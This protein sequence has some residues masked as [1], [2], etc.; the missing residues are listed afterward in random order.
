MDKKRIESL[1]ALRGLAALVV[2][3]RHYTTIFSIDYGVP[4]NFNFEFKYGYLGVE[5]FFLISG[6]VI[7][8]TIEQVNTSKEFIVKRFVRLY[9]TYWLSILITTIVILLFGLPKMQFSIKDF[10]LNLTMIQDVVNPILH[11]KHIDGVYWSLAAELLFYGFILLL[12]Q[13]KWLKYI[14]VIGFFWVLISIICIPN[15]ISVLM[16]GI[17]FNLK[18]SPLFFGGILFYKLWKYD[19]EKIKWNTHFLILFSLISYYILTL[20]KVE[21]ESKSNFIECIVITFFFLVF[22]LVAFQ[23]LNFLGKGKIL[24]FLGKI[25]YPLYLLHQ[26]IGYIILFYLINKF[27]FNNQLILLIPIL[28]SILLASLIVFKFEAVYLSR[29]KKYLLNKL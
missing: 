5:L 22:Y 14:K 12:F 21:D 29:L 10:L 13:L 15:D 18:W 20:T 8:M 3:L 9:P 26:N 6:F 17:I 25:S 7:F 16:L 1:D 11:T 19:T 24:L 28:V 27:Q 4:N 23:K 2:M